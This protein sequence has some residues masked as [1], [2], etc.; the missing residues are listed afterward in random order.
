MRLSKLKGLTEQ[1]G[2][3][4]QMNKWRFASEKF[5]QTIQNYKKEHR[6]DKTIHIP[7]GDI[8]SSISVENIPFNPIAAKSKYL[9]DIVCKIDFRP[10]MNPKP[11]IPLNLLQVTVADFMDSIKRI[12]PDLFNKPSIYP[13]D[14]LDMYH[15]KIQN[16][17]VYPAQGILTLKDY[18]DTPTY[19][20]K[21]LNP[22]NF[23][24]LLLS[25]SYLLNA[26]QLIPGDLP[27]FADDYSSTME[28]L[29]KKAGSVYHALKKGTWRGHSYELFVPHDW[30]KA[31]RI[32]QENDNYNKTTKVLHSNFTVACNLGWETVDGIKNSPEE[33]PLSVEER[34]EFIQ[35]LKNRF[36]QFDIL[37]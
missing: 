35:F 5:I 18:M 3:E 36:K 30:S 23:G 13:L 6:F 20:L 37:Y 25:R 2:Q 22:H 34:K 19:N 14:L 17:Y 24:G 10:K 26:Y 16:L 31:F 8:Q 7:E 15:F 33:S 12:N 9:G 32:F 21:V 29:I 1:D 28:K 11:E 4:D 27:T